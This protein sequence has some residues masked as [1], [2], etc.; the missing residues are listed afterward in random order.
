LCSLLKVTFAGSSGL[1]SF[2]WV[3]TLLLHFTL[4]AALRPLWLTLKASLFPQSNLMA[5]GH[6]TLF[7]P[8]LTQV[9]GILLFL[10]SFL[11]IFLLFS[12]SLPPP[13]SL[14]LG[15]GCY[16][17]TY[18]IF[19]LYNLYIYIMLYLINNVNKYNPKLFA[20]FLPLGHCQGNA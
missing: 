11:A 1:S 19:N 9:P 15:L 8:I 12:S 4:F 10:C 3:L 2:L 20:L 6:L 18:V 5:P 16:I 13:L 7:W 17:Y 14:S